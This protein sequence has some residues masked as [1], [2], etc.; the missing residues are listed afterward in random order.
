MKH[1]RRARRRSQHARRRSPPD[2]R[3]AAMPGQRRSIEDRSG[4]PPV[5]VG[6]PGIPP[7]Q[8]AAGSG[9]GEGFA[10]NAH[11]FAPSGMLAAVK[12]L[13]EET[14]R[15]RQRRGLR[16]QHRAAPGR[17]ARRR[18]D[19]PVS[20]LEGRRSDAV[21]REGQ[22]TADMANGPVQRTQPYPRSAR[23]AGQA[24]REESRQVRVLLGR[25]AVEGRYGAAGR[26]W[27]RLQPGLAIT[28]IDTGARHRS[29]RSA[30]R[31]LISPTNPRLAARS[32]RATRPCAR[33]RAL[34]PGATRALA[35]D[36]GAGARACSAAR[37]TTP[38]TRRCSR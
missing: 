35:R 21:N 14:G 19:D 4:K 17:G 29:P 6:G 18:R 15:G 28:S 3:R 38:G 23:S 20:R 26:L 9:Y 34:R 5:P 13:V 12:Y 32:C 11:R 30:A 25:H 24:R 16:R 27:A 8:A 1:A 7:L 22:S 31:L 33:S 37:D 2:A 36:R 10:G